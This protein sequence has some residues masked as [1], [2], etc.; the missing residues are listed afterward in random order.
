MKSRAKVT[1]IILAGGR[2][3][4]MGGADKGLVKLQQKV[5][6]EHVIERLSPQVDEIII[7][8]NRNQV[9]YESMGYAVTS[10][11]QN[12]D[13]E[14]KFAGPLAG[15]ASAIKISTTPLILVTPCDTP[16]I[17]TNLLEMLYTALEE[18]SNSIAVAHDGERIQPLFFLAKREIINSI[19]DRL[20][21]QQPRVY[22][23]MESLNPTV[24]HFSSLL[25][26]SNIN[27]K[28]ERDRVEDR[29][30]SSTPVIGFA[31]WSGSGK[32]TLLIELIQ[33]L[34]QRGVR[35][36][37]IKHT[38]HD[39]NFDQPGKDS[40]ELRKAGAE[41]MLVA[42]SKRWMLINE[43]SETLADAKLTPLIHKLDHKNLDLILVEG[44][45]HEPIPRI[46]IY[47]SELGKPPLHHKDGY[48]IAVATPN[49]E[50]I[51]PQIP[52]LDLNNLDE[53]INFISAKITNI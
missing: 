35:V 28:E 8:A 48:I 27:T 33:A 46:E 9:Q 18:S 45:K 13:A 34:K 51:A 26:F 22:R 4:R 12:D 47:R 24:V 15:I 2:G 16:F 49:S 30:Q 14:D 29:L 1:G 20:S 25:P 11:N 31:G 52:R 40:Y 19:Q 43:N 23:W 17:P 44:F 50:D 39:V 6:I 32:T 10:D 41:Q 53:I 7:S 36:A 37:A 3:S 42:S 5:M 21:Q 38:H